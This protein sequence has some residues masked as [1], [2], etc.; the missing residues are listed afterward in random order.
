MK[1]LRE[2]AFTSTLWSA[3]ERFGTQGLQFIIIVVLARILSPKDF[4]LIG[5]LAIFIAL[6]RVFVDSALGTALIRK[7]DATS[8]DYSTVFIFNIFVGL[9][10]YL[11]LFFTAPYIANFYNEPK[12]VMLTR[13]IS[14]NFLI[15]S[16]GSIHITIFTKKLDF[17]T[18]TKI[19][20]LSN[21]ISGIVAI[22]LAYLNYGVWALVIQSI[23]YSFTSTV[24]YWF[25]NAWK[26]YLKFSTESFRNLF[27]F[28]SKLLISILIDTIFQNIYLVIIGKWFNVSD[29]GYYTQAKKIQETPSLTIN[30]IIQ[31]VSFPVFSSIQDED[32]RLKVGLRKTIKILVFVLFPI[33]LGL[34]SVSDSFVRII[35]S[36]KWIN[37]IVY[38]KLLCIVGILYPLQSI[39]LNILNVKGRSDIFLRLEIVRKSL[40][41]LSIAIGFRWGIIGMVKANV[42][43]S[44]INYLIVVV[45]SGKLINYN[46]K[47]QLLDLLPYAVTSTVMAIIITLITLNSNF[48]LQTLII[49]IVLGIIIYLGLSV[50]F[51]LEALNEM[52][53]LVRPA[54]TKNR[55]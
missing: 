47:E 29:L 33:M 27:G 13:V 2:H 7:Q 1:S 44:I 42:I 40:I 28:S 51:K 37:S 45:V 49:Q 17:K 25:S 30:N 31:R 39:N 35:F 48:N 55:K 38:L 26:P 21:L 53:K 20:V 24:L 4:G 14:L 9:I 6:A 12:L 22:T 11:F 23:S 34:L 54:L 8:E 15:G 43:A 3:L 36:E 52:L 5:M 32:K 46:I 18:Q 16:F 50:L 10:I 19:S 41:I